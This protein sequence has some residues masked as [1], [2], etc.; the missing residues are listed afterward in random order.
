MN[1]APSNRAAGRASIVLSW[2]PRRVV[3]DETQHAVLIRKGR[4]ERALEAGVHRIVPRNDRAR[5]EAATDQVITVPGQEMLTAD[6]ASVRATVGVT[7]AVV[8]PVQVAKQGGWHERFYLGVQLA[9][10]NAIAAMT[11]E[12]TLANR[13]SLDVDLTVVVAASADELGLVVR[14]AAVRD[15]MVPGELKRAVAEV[16]SARLS[17]LAAL[18]RA[19]GETAALRS[20]ANAAKVAA[21]NPALLQLRLIQQMETTSG[22]TYV[23][24]TAP[25][26]G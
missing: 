8:D 23:L 10:R 21:D 9:L 6:G 20:L 14:S 18:E 26:L 22:H 24:G 1:Y 2:I 11:L 12:E 3:V 4:V 16:V 17:G 19:R 7:M 15:F 13:N 5:Y 25:T